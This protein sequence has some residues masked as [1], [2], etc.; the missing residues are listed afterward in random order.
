MN[1][2]QAHCQKNWLDA[3]RPNRIAWPWENHGW[4]RNLHRSALK[5]NIKTI[6]YQHTVIGPHQ[7]NYAIHTNHDGLASIPDLVV[8]DGPSYLSEMLAW[9][10][11]ATRLVIGGAFRFPRFADDLYDPRGPVFVPLS[12]IFDAARAQLDIARIIA[13]KGRCVLIK[14][15]PMYPI[16]FD[17]SKKLV[18][19]ECSLAE[20]RGLSAVLYTTGASG[21]EA[22]LM[23]IPGYRLIL[24][25]RI[26]IDV[27]P[28]GFST[29]TVTTTNAAEAVLEGSASSFLAAW[30]DI[31]S[32]PD[33]GLWKSLLF[34]DI[35]GPT[36]TLEEHQ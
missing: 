10:I 36:Q 14:P 29:Q 5:R 24:D 23:G 16:A 27:L 2:W 7:F 19:V 11:P 12:A 17:E 26:S 31:F 35:D 1:R 25:D 20:H 4:E 22:V 3:A 32:D 15:H 13:A 33:I 6:G 9:G 28:F 34:G 30:D 8:A 18:R 21:L